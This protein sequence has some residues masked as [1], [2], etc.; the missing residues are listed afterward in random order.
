MH[1]RQ[2]DLGYVPLAEGYARSRREVNRALALDPGLAEAHAAVGWIKSSYDWD[3][4]G[5]DAAY[6]RALELEPTHAGVM[7]GAAWLAGT[8]GRLDEA[9][10]LG[11]RAIEL[12]P[13]MVAAYNNLATHAYY[14]GRLDEAEEAARK[15]LALNPSYPEVREI[16]GLVHLARSKPAEALAEIRKEQ[17]SWRVL[18]GEAL[19]F[20]AEGRKGPADAALA[21]FTKDN[22]DVGAFQIAEIHAFRN[23]ADEAFAWLERAYRQRDG[24][25]TGVKGSPLLRSIRDDERYPALLRK[26]K[27]PTS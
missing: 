1:S 19:V 6:R 10:A 24:G 9:L 20:H 15:A 26:L 12:D 25:L 17:D 3:W 4:A 16:L 2:A 13:L 8:L 27:L 21:K 7:Q 5:A 22:G 14:A 11:R 18:Y 23:E